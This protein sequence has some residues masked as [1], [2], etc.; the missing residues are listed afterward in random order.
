M[1]DALPH[2]P[3]SA[4]LKGCF[5]S[6]FSPLTRTRWLCLFVQAKIYEDEDEARKEEIVALGG[7][8]IYG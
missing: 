8:D 5:A 6:V 7:D 1:L 2:L 3:V 4:Q